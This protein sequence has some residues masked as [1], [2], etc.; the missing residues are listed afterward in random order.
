MSWKRLRHPSTAGYWIAAG[1]ALVG[2][3]GAVALGAIGYVQLQ[4][5]L[6]ALPG[7][8]VP[9]TLEVDVDGASGVTIFYEDPIQ[10]GFLVRAG[11]RTRSGSRRSTWP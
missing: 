2:V 3:L 10:G 9:G 5:R 8:T 1:L 6:E 4:D 11:A 7:A